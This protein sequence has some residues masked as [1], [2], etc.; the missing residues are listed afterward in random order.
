M[1]NTNGHPRAVSVVNG[2]A[3]SN[4]F[5]AKEERAKTCVI[6]VRVSTKKQA[7]AYGLDAQIDDCRAWAEREGYRVLAEFKDSGGKDSKRDTN[8]WDLKGFGELLRFIESNRVDVVIATERSRYGQDWRPGYIQDAMLAPHGTTLRA[9][10]DTGNVYGDAMTDTTSGEERRKIAERSK[11]GKL[12]KARRGYVIALGQPNFG[13]LY[14]Q[15]RKG[16]TLAPE[17]MRVVQR[18]IYMVGVEHLSLHAVKTTMEKEG[19]DT[20][21][22]VWSEYTARERKQQGEKVKEYSKKWSGPFIRGVI[23]QDVYKAHTAEEIAELVEQGHMRPETAAL[24]PVP[25]GI[26]WYE[27]TDW[28]GSKV[29]VAVPVP[30]SG[31]PREWVDLARAQIAGNVKSMPKG[32][33]RFWELGGG[34]F[35]CSCGWSM[36]GHSRRGGNG[37]SG[38]KYHS[39]R[40]AKR[41]RHGKNACEQRGGF[42]ADAVEAQVWEFVAE[43]LSDP[44]LVVEGLDNAIER[45]RARMQGDPEREEMVIQDRLN[46]LEQERRGYLRQNARGI[47]PDDELDEELAGLDEQLQALRHAR[48]ELRRAGGR[49]RALEGMRL[50]ALEDLRKFY[51]EPAEAMRNIIERARAKSPDDIPA[52]MWDETTRDVIQE[53][54]RGGY[55]KRG[56]RRALEDAAPE[57][58]RERYR[59]LGIQ[60]RAVPDGSIEVEG[61]CIPE[62]ASRSRGRR[63]SCG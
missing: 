26:W 49:I 54:E 62:D 60:V 6:Y 45:E 61:V 33:N 18:V 57:Q 41:V 17:H 25:C 3:P 27:G 47:L 40:C 20:P 51:A 15:D 46:A 9:L 36:Q 30:D 63:V 37:G 56:M 44:A 42:N 29:R 10:N 7:E 23:A 53:W 39:Y 4:A 2:D 24:A 38:I 50:R 28:D 22:K 32:G 34:V 5:S 13:F 11:R 35:K 43:Y 8:P 59:E 48:D 58:R 55:V 52:N 12:N 21:S 14:T 31:I 19:W 16:Y 1:T